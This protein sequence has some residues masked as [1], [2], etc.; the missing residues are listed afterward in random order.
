MQTGTGESITIRQAHS[1]LASRQSPAS[2]TC[3]QSPASQGFGQAPATVSSVDTIEDNYSTNH[4]T[5][6]E[7]QMA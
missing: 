2:L 1:S 4:Q 5:K 7:Q 6:D 3:R